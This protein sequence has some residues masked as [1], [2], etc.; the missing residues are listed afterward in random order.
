MGQNLNDIVGHFAHFEKKIQNIV[1]TCAS[2]QSA[3]LVV[4]ELAVEDFVRGE[5]DEG[6]V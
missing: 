1:R 5:V 6:R 3:L 2:S 4:R